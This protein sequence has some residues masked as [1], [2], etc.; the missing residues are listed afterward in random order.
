MFL[1]ETSFHCYLEHVAPSPKSLCYKIPSCHLIMVAAIHSYFSTNTMPMNTKKTTVSTYHERRHQ[2]DMSARAALDAVLPPSAV[3]KIH[4]HDNEYGP[5]ARICI[6]ARKELDTWQTRHR[7][8]MAVLNKQSD[9]I[10]ALIDE[11]QQAIDQLQAANEQVKSLRE[12]NRGLTTKLH[13]AREKNVILKKCQ[14]GLLQKLYRSR[15]K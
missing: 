10:S 3:D 7:N 2:N 9:E 5:V 11:K 1:S 6:A 8:L 13:I 12:D 4:P 15:R 14:R